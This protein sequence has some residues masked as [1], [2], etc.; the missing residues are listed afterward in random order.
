MR[1]SGMSRNYCLTSFL[2]MIILLSISVLF[3]TPAFASEEA[4]GH[5]ETVA[6]GWVATDTYRVINFAILAGVLFFILKKPASQA[7]NSRITGIKEQLEE[8]EMKKREAEKELARH[9]EKL[10]LLDKEAEKIVEE[11]IRQGNEAKARILKEAEL[12]A[13]KLEIKAKRNIEH[14]FK[15]AKIQLQSEIIEQALVKAEKKIIEKISSE[16]QD[17]LVDEYL[18]KVVA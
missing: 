8:L 17:R 1:K 4:G 3:C 16:D 11:Y 5:G 12:S 9:K 13:E 15:Q 2:G 7:L 18:E 6:K 10:A 14:E